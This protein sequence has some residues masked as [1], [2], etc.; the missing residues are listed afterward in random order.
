VREHNNNSVA[1]GKERVDA[2]AC[3]TLDRAAAAIVSAPKGAQAVTLH[4]ACYA[5]GG[6]VAIGALDY[7][8]AYGKLTEAAR[9]MPAYGELW[10][11]LERKVEASLRRGMERP[12]MPLKGRGRP[13]TTAP[14]QCQSH[15]T[16]DLANGR[17]T[18]MDALRTWRE[19]IDPRGTL[20]ER[21]LVEQRKLDLCNDLAGEVLRWHPG[22]GAMLALFR[23]ILTGEPQAIS[24][25][26]LDRHG[27]KIERKFV[28]P[29][30][31]AAVMLDPFNCVTHGLFVGEG[32]ET[33]MAGRQW[34]LKPAWALGSAGAIET[35]PVLDGVEC[36]TILAEHCARNASAVEVCG[37]RWSAAGREVLINRSI[38]GKDLN[39]AVMKC[40][41]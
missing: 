34:D 9:R 15:I 40:A 22:L 38:V 29:I 13:Q 8:D 5:I 23:N 11:R 33:C 19:A 24:R 39:D 36:L 10:T 16:V 14:R 25:I 41:S 35:F 30:G 1:D 32:V 28:G 4:R 3:A 27:R 12:W 37:C 2:Y 18:T 20:A 17:T 31:G 7:R 26:F 6:L 21:Y